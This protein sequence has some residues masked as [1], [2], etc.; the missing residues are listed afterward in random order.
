MNACTVLP[1]ASTAGWRVGRLSGR[2]F[3]EGMAPT[4]SKQPFEG[5]PAYRM[6]ITTLVDNRPARPDEAFARRPALWPFLPQ[7]S[8]TAIPR[9]RAGWEGP[10]SLHAVDNVSGKYR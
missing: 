10:P 8:L 1:M 6:A 3:T 9:A 4:L 2:H 7:G 5:L